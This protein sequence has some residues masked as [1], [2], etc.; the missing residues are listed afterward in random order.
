MLIVCKVQIQ[1]MRGWLEIS[2]L[3]KWNALILTH[4]GQPSAE[5]LRDFCCTLLVEAASLEAAHQP[6]KDY[7]C[8]HMQKSS[9]RPA[10]RL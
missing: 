2:T 9:T 10:N 3:Y 5:K 8:S 6:S 1:T 4:D 7:I